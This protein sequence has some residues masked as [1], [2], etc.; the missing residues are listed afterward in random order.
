MALLFLIRYPLPGLQPSVDGKNEVVEQIKEEQQVDN[1]SCV[2][3]TSAKEVG[4]K[5][6]GGNNKGSRIG[7]YLKVTNLPEG[8]AWCAAF[9]CWVMEQCGLDHPSSAWSPVVATHNT[10]Y[11]RGDEYF[12]NMQ[13]GLVFGLYYENLK[14]IG[15]VGIIYKI[16]GNKVYTIEGNTS[17]SKTREGDGVH[18]LIRPKKSIYRISKYGKRKNKDA[19]TRSNGISTNS[20]SNIAI[21]R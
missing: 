19:N 13:D 14:R 16:Q 20:I 2:L 21:P 17:G 5:E 7:E 12:P 8:Y 11:K 3:E 15:H 1:L 4:V 18:R 9:V 10:I 6:Y